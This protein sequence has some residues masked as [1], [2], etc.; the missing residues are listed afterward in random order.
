MRCVPLQLHTYRVPVVFHQLIVDQFLIRLGHGDRIQ[1]KI[2]RDLAHRR[3]R[4][5]LFQDA[6]RIIATTRS[7]SW[8]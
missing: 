4:V 3:K 6:V 7:R 2:R 8:R 1:L 5:A